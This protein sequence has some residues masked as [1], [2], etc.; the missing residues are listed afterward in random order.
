M[1]VYLP[2]GGSRS[3]VDDKVSYADCVDGDL[4]SLLELNAMLK[5]LGYV[6]KVPMWYHFRAPDS[7]LY[8]GLHDLATHSD[9]RFLDLCV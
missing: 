3:Y 2:R 6:K 5:D 9:V 7:D 4:F 8:F 1:V